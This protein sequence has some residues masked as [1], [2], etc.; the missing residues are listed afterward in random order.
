MVSLEQMVELAGL[1]G[2]IMLKNGAETYR[3][4]ETMEHMAKAC[5]AM[6]VESFVTPTGAFLTVTDS[7]G[8]FITAMRRVRNRT[9]NLDRISKVNELSRRLVDGRIGYGDAFGILARIGRER[10]GFSWAPSM[11]ASGVV[12]GGTAVLQNGGTVEILASFGAA[13]AVRY[14]A[15]IISRLHGVQFT[16]EFLGGITAALAGTVLHEIWP[17]LGRDIVII[18]GVMPLVPGVAITNAIRDVMAGD[19]LSG[20]SRGMEA[21][22]TSVAITMGVVIVLAIHLV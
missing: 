2:E 19:L 17:Q 3:V 11:L 21:A 7:S 6:K 16:F 12:G 14:V 15:H 9:S 22:L 20:L 1:A 10:T 13:A 5:G 8:R 4:E 18:G